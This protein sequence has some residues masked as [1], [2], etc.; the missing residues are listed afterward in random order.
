[1]KKIYI[2]LIAVMSAA[3]VSR[4]GTTMVNVSDNVF[5]P[6]N[7]TVTVGDTILWM[8]VNGTHTTSSTSIPVGAAAWNQ[9][10]DQNNT[11][12]MYI[13]STAGNYNY[14]CNFHVSMGMVG[15]FTA[16]QSSGLN[17][18]IAGV[19]LGI[20]ANPINQQL[21]VDLKTKKTGELTI[22]LNDITGRQV[23]LLSSGNQ[24]AGEHHFQFELAELPKGIYLF[25][26][27]IGGD[28]LVRKII[29]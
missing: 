27:S 4:A 26:V 17:E 1:M 20:F 5:A 29:L 23:K 8:W 6:N 28:E 14:Q 3:F 12:Y 10:I 18:N 22:T 15:Q 24:V 21:N 16:E 19:Y 11:S 13:V 7:F 2:I 9:V 25:K